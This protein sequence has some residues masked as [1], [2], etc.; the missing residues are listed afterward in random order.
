MKCLVLCADLTPKV[1]KLLSFKA[2]EALSSSLK[3]NAVAQHAVSC[4]TACR[5]STGG[6]SRK[7]SSPLSLSP[8]SHHSP[9]SK[10]LST[11]TLWTA[12]TPSSACHFHASPTQ[13]SPATTTAMLTESE[14]V[15]PACGATAPSR[16]SSRP[17]E[18]AWIR[19]PAATSMLVAVPVG[20]RVQAGSSA[21]SRS[22]RLLNFP[23]RSRGSRASRICLD[24]SPLSPAQATPVALQVPAA[25]ATQTPAVAGTAEEERSA[26]LAVAAAAGRVRRRH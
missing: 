21:G 7:A 5:R 24:P 3:R 6:S 26:V 1:T 10:Q 22:S 12:R 16:S 19:A 25:T 20:R 8:L 14:Q 2:P 15:P 13:P 23:L 18:L 4:I 17:F 9:N 11:T